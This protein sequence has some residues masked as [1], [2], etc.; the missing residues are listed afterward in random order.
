[1]WWADEDGCAYRDELRGGPRTTAWFAARAL[2][3]FALPILA[4]VR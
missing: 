2:M 1:M 4:L 3:S